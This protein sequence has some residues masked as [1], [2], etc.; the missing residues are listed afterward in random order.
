[1]YLMPILDLNRVGL[2][3][4]T[5]N[6]GISMRPAFMS[7]TE[8]EKQKCRECRGLLGHFRAAVDVLMPMKDIDEVG[9][10]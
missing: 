9:K 10:I 4:I 2:K 8:A 1:M 7:T 6:E 3:K 5:L